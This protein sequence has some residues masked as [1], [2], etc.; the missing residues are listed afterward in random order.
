MHQISPHSHSHIP[1]HLSSLLCLYH[2]TLFS[3]A[4]NHIIPVK[5]QR[6]ELV[7]SIQKSRKQ[8]RCGGGV[9]ALLYLFGWINEGPFSD[10]SCC[11][12]VITVHHGM[13]QEQGT[14]VH[15]CWWFKEEKR[16]WAYSTARYNNHSRSYNIVFVQVAGDVQITVVGVAVTEKA[17][18]AGRFEALSEGQIVVEIP[19][20]KCRDVASP[21]QFLQKHTV[22]LRK[23]TQRKKEKEEVGAYIHRGSQGRTLRKCLWLT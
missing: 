5:I 9:V 22:L 14:S 19:A 1:K 7:T 21:V 2:S 6:Q 8:L 11:K 3:P 18:L 4:A 10:T 23:T 20:P 12:H 17:N 16:L 15:W 13:Q